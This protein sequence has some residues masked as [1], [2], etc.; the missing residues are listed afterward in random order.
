MYSRRIEKLFK[1]IFLKKT[2]FLATDLEALLMVNRNYRVRYYH[3]SVPKRV[4][5]IL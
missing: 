4:E 3:C 1:I 2:P 5:Y